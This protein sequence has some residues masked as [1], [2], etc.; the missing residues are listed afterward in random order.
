[1]IPRSAVD[2]ARNAAAAASVVWADGSPLD[3]SLRSLGAKAGGPEWDEARGVAAD[4]LQEAQSSVVEK[5]RDASDSIWAESFGSA[6][7]EHVHKAGF[8]LFS[9]SVFDGAAVMFD[10]KGDPAEFSH[11]VRGWLAGEYDRAYDKAMEDSA[12][13]VPGTE[14][15]YAHVPA[16]PKPCARCLEM[17]SKGFSYERPPRAEN[18]PGCQC[19]VVPGTVKTRVEGYDPEGV[20]DRIAKCAETVGIDPKTDDERLRKLVRD[21]MGTRDAVWLATGAVPIPS[22]ETKALMMEILR[23]RPHEIRTAHRL[24]EVGIRSD[25]VDDSS[26]LADLASGVELKTLMGTSSYNTINGY[27][28]GTSK[29]KT[30]AKAIVFDNFENDDADDKTIKDFVLRSRSFR[31]GKIYIFGKDEKLSFIR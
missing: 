29:T 14:V 15:R 24:S 2:G 27:I 21:E 20:A 1:M 5:A 26:G 19:V 10:G 11:K 23:E 17:A 4:I 8:G 12:A 28:K 3:M 31:R 22:F 16:G 30:N 25:F 13:T 9:D 18:H 6:P 7:A